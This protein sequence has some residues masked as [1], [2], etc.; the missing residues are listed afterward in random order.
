MDFIKN[1]LTQS[2]IHKFLYKGEERE[3]LCPLKIYS[4]SIAKTHDYV[5]ESMNKG[6]YF[7]TLCLGSG[8]GGKVTLDL[9]RKA[10]PRKTVLENAKRKQLGLP[11]IKGDKTLD[12][13]RIEEQAIKFKALCAKYQVVVT[14]GNVQLRIT[15]PWHKNPNIH[16]SGGTDIFPTTIMTSKG[17]QLAII[18]L[19]LTADVTSGFGE[20]SWGAPEFMDHT[21]GMLYS[22]LVRRLVNHIDMNP[23]MK[24]VLTK[25]AVELITRDQVFFYYWVFGYKKIENKFV[26]VNWDQNRENEL[27]EAIRKCVSLI[28]YYESLS[29][30]ARP[31]YKTCKECTVFECK[32]RENIEKV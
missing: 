20:F 16:L 15:L 30:P 12:Q 24:E 8:V 11:E 31:D 25:P 19:K 27:H 10:L 9:P 21:Q 17:I 7:E 5:T 14:D 22:Y 32:S 4:T 2:L 29:W 23:H 6:N 1:P 13:V 28:E 18:D 3:K 26:E